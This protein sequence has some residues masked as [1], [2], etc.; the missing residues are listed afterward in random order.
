MPPLIYGDLV[1]VGPAGSENNIQGWIG[2][3]SLADGAPVWRFNT[4]PKAGEP[5]FETWNNNPYVPV[6]GG[7]VW[8]PVSLDVDRGELYVPVTNPAPDFAKD[9]RPGKNLYTN[10]LLALDVRTGKLRWYAQLVTNDDRD[11]DLTQVS[12]L[13]EAVVRGKKR[14]LV[15]TAGKDGIVRVLDRDTHEV[16]HQTVIGTRLN[17]HAPITSAGTHYCPGI[18][19]GIQW[20]GP[21]WHPGLEHALRTLGRL[22]LDRHA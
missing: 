2:A 10:S 8:T 1:I 16:L 19:G 12:P 5:G 22:V 13:I 7:S 6:G 3:F 21:A 20:N 4:V 17:E 9:L 18:F 11:W 14:K 15:V